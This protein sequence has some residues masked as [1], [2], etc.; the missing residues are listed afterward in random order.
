LTKRCSYTRDPKKEKTSSRNLVEIVPTNIMKKINWG[1]DLLGYSLT[2][3]ELVRLEAQV[4]SGGGEGRADES[5]W[6]EKEKVLG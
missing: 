2:R 5:E 4:E 6:N 3:E 1:T